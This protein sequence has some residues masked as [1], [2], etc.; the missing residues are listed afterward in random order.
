[1]KCDPFELVIEDVRAGKPVVLV[2]DADRENEGDITIA[3]EC[4]TPELINFM[5]QE[6]RGLIC[7]SLTEVHARQLALPLQVDQNTAAF[8]TNFMTSLDYHAVADIGVSAEGRARTIQEAVKDTAKATDFVRPGYVFPVRAVPAGVLQRRGQTEGSVDLAR[9]A[10]LKPAGVICEVMDQDG[11][12]LS[13]S[14]LEAY[15]LRWGFRITSIEA[16]VRYRL[17]NEIS[18]RCVAQC[19][20]QELSGL[21]IERELFGCEDLQVFVFTDDVDNEEH[22]AF[23]RGEPQDGCLV[24]IHSECL[25]GDVFSSRRCD[26]GYQL[27]FA[28][29]QILA[30][31]QGIV[32][33][34]HQEGRG[35]GLGNK[36]RAYQ[37]QDSGLDTVDANLELGFEAD[38]RSYRAGAKI[39][40]TFGLRSVRLLTNN[41]D[42]VNEL[43]SYGIRVVERIGVIAPI[44]EHNRRYL[45]TKRLRLGHLF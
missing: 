16:I 42:K 19:S 39:L 25:T 13:G 41:P 44:D 24:R 40:E 8:G 35:I 10:G 38:A 37:L 26:C 20:I 23:V 30:A 2:D 5:A 1:M 4:V 3:A 9:I 32:V 14:T 34:L 22:L 15:C 36:L 17:Q 12:M 7:L 6:A 45:E 33:Y 29:R 43:E 18:L 21:G 31:G 11:V 27:K 28:L